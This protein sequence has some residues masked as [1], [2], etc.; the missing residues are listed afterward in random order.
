MVKPLVKYEVKTSVAGSCTIKNLTLYIYIL[1]YQK[2]I[3]LT[4]AGL[5]I[6]LHFAELEKMQ[7]ADLAFDHDRL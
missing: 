3:F 7:I 4:D 6:Y 2:V 5:F 1:H